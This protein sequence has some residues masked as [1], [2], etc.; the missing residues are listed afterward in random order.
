MVRKRTFVWA[1]PS[2][3]KRQ[4]V[5]SVSGLEYLREMK[6]GRISPSPAGSLIGYRLIEVEKG[7][8]VFECDIK[9]YHYNPFETVHGGIMT[10]ILDA[11]MTASV[12]SAQPA[13][14]SCTTVEFK[15]N[16]VRPATV[17]NSPLQC[18]ASAVHIGKKLATVTGIL[19]DRQGNIYA[20]GLGTCAI[21]KVRT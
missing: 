2:E 11:A 12:L 15:M 13:G 6:D 14:Y 18:D 17:E 19:K 9:E 8:A 1:D 4:A 20:H 16:F 10:C 21:F 7:R 5:S 3:N